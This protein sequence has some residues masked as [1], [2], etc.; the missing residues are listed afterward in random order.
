MKCTLYAD[1]LGKYLQSRLVNHTQRKIDQT[2]VRETFVPMFCAFC[3]R[4][5]RSTMPLSM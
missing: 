2:M 4:L 1:A 5:S 3:G